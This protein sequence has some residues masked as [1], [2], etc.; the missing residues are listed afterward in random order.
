MEKRL[1]KKTEEYSS[2]FKNNVREFA[3][4]IGIT[5]TDPTMNSLLQYIYDYKRLEF[6]KSDLT[7][8]KRVKNTVPLFERYCANRANGEQC[9]RRK[10]EDAE[11][12]GTHMKGT[13]H[14][15]M[16]SQDDTNAKSSNQQIEVWAQDIRGIIYYLD[17]YGNVY[18]PE[19]IITNK[20]NPRIIAKYVHHGDVYSIPEMNV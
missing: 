9:T 7:R 3:S 19:D 4:K 11:Y 18:Q 13:P 12:C 5:Q 14:G 15:I 17:K 8:R 10:K 6:D 16:S 2:E 1:N 20:L